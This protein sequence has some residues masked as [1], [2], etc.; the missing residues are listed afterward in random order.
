MTFESE[1]KS[2][3]TYNPQSGKMF[4]GDKQVGWENKNGYIYISTP[5]RRKV[6]A[7]RLA[8]LLYYGDWPANDVDHIN[9]NRSDNRIENLRQLSRSQNLLNRDEPLLKG[10]HWDKTRGKWQSGIGR[11]GNKKRFDNFCDAYKYR[12][13][14]YI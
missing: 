9:R 1:L 8:W 7:H 6:L 14:Q 10:I 12:K 4:M 5:L 2:L 3:Y 13:E 11:Q